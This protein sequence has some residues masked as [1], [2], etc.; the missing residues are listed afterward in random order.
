MGAFDFALSGDQFR[1]RPSDFAISAAQNCEMEDTNRELETAQSRKR[2]Y[3][4]SRRHYGQLRTPRQN[5]KIGCKTVSRFRSETHS[6]PDHLALSHL[7][8]IKVALHIRYAAIHGGTLLTSAREA[9]V[10]HSESVFLASVSSWQSADRHR[11]ASF[12]WSA[13]QV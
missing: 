7:C 13:A 4:K 10:A 12:S 9:D 3:A 8:V 11:I 5:R 6:R 1:D 2:T